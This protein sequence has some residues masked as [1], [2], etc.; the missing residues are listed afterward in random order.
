MSTKV[1]E[2]ETVE[3]LKRR[4]D[5]AAK[6]LPLDQLA[7]SPQCGFAS[8]EKGTMLSFRDQDAKLRRVVETAMEVWGQV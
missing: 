1:P 6:Y 5:A 4:I 8:H 3:D 2:I 7:I